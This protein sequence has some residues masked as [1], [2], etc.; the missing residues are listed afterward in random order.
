MTLNIMGMSV[1]QSR[2]ETKQKRT[3]SLSLFTFLCISQI[4]V[5]SSF[6]FKSLL[7]NIIKRILMETQATHSSW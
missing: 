1:C 6:F 7:N 2:N 4:D 5:M 3:L